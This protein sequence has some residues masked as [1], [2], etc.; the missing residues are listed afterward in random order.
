MFAL[1]G[2]L[3]DGIARLAGSTSRSGQD[4]LGATTRR[5][6][7]RYQADTPAVPGQPIMA[8]DQEALAYAVYRMP[9]TYAAIRTVLDQLP[10]DAV[11]PAARHLDIA[12][13]TGSAV[14][15]VAD[16]WPR[17]GQQTLLEQSAAA[18]SVGRRLAAATTGPVRRAGWER[19][20]I[21]SEIDPGAADVITIGYLLSEIDEPLRTALVRSCLAAARDL[22]IIVE[23]GTKNGY[24]RILAARD[25]AI[26]AG[27]QLVAPCPHRLAC[28]LAD[29][30]R[31][32]CHFS[33][34]VNR[35]TA[36][37]RAKGAELG[38]EDEKF[39]YLVAAPEATA[40][41][42][43]RVLRHPTFR[44]GLV[45]LTVCQS[46]GEAERVTVAKRDQDHYRAARKIEWG[47]PWP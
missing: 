2:E 35:S 1:P 4:H 30:Q 15:A 22:L 45:E 39:S 34:R 6:I 27:W 29:Q 26:D 10:D 44:K 8:G 42:A 7:D 37:R 21:N 33:A 14:W 31:D 25:Q 3:A 40:Q 11:R 24:R 41:A 5:M 17:I 9:A 36:H 16:R 32:W 12:G 47:D 46:S 19:R 28:P 38:Y 23:P 13:G 18:I 43:G 20:V